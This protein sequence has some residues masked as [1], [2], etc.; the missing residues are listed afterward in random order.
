MIQIHVPDPTKEPGTAPPAD[1]LV[2]AA[3]LGAFDVLDQITSPPAYVMIPTFGKRSKA[4]SKW[5]SIGNGDQKPSG[6]QS[7]VKFLFGGID[8]VTGQIQTVGSSVADRPP[9]LTIDDPGA[10]TTARI[11]PGG[12]TL[13]L[14]GAALNAIRAGT[15]SGI[16]NDVYLRTPALLADCAV[17]MRI[18]ENDRQ[19]RGLLDRAGVLRRGSA[20]ARRRGPASDGRRLRPLTAFNSTGAD[21]TTGFQLMPRFFQVITNGIRT[22]SSTL[23]EPAL[24]GGARQRH[25]APDEGNLLQDWTSGITDFNDKPAGALQFFRY[26]VEFDLDKNN[27]GITAET[28]PVTLDFLKLPFV[29]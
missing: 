21:G 14:T 13:E 7:Q 29:F 10:S 12:F 4:R 27:Q 17:R 8:P 9:L 2:P 20:R 24:P 16:S 25:Q 28:E 11:L 26:E 22:L 19:L 15:T 5:I 1:I 18:K 6:T 3:A 23:R